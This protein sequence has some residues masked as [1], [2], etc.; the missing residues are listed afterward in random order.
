MHWRAFAQKDRQCFELEHQFDQNIFDFVLRIRDN[1]SHLIFD[2]CKDS[3]LREC[4]IVDVGLHLGYLESLSC[5][6]VMWDIIG[7]KG[8]ITNGGYWAPSYVKLAFETTNWLITPVC[9]DELITRELVNGKYKEWAYWSVYYF[10]KTCA[11]HSF[12]I[13]FTSD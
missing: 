8:I 12:G 9:R 7:D 4:P 3:A 5:G 10:L 11:E 2:F 1:S 13:A 6:F